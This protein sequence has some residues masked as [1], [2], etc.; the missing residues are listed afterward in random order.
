FHGIISVNRFINRWMPDT[1]TDIY[2]DYFEAKSIQSAKAHLTKLANTTELFSWVQSW[3]NEKRTYTG[4]D[5]RWLSWSKI[6]TGMTD[7]RQE[8]ARTDRMSERESGES[9][10]TEPYNRY[11]TS[12]QYRVDLMLRWLNE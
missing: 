9:I 6:R 10:N 1:T 12:A 11:G 8:V 4:K 5:V 2:D 3:D 7:K